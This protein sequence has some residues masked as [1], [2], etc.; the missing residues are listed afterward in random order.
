MYAPC[1]T[2]PEKTKPV[3]KTSEYMVLARDT[4]GFWVELGM[5]DG[6]KAAARQAED[7]GAPYET[8]VAVPSRSWKP[9]TRKT[10]QRTH[11]S[12]S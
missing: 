7:E 5:F 4:A 10:E 12:W 1:M 2:T 3:S 11:E 6:V 9:K 8:F